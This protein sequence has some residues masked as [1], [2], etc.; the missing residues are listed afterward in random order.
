MYFS[1]SQE[2]SSYRV[3]IFVFGVHWCIPSAYNNSI[4]G[5]EQMFGEQMNG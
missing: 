5:P 3:G 4:V 2:V 1:P